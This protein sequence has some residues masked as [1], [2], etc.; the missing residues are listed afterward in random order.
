MVIEPAAQSLEVADAV[1]VEVHVGSDVQAVNNGVL[2]P[3]VVYSHRIIFASF[4]M[5]IW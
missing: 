5:V 3:V 4:V 1:A 2:E